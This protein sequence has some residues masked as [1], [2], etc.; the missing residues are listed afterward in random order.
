MHICRYFVPVKH[1]DDHVNLGGET[2]ITIRKRCALG[3]YH[4]KI[5]KITALTKDVRVRKM[6]VAWYNLNFISLQFFTN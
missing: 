1:Y 4:Q 6:L 2:R 5:L 3:K